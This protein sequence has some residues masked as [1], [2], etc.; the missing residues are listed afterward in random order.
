EV[1][2]E[3]RPVREGGV[4]GDPGLQRHRFVLRLAG[5]LAAGDVLTRLAVLDHLG[6]PLQGAHLGQPGDVLVV[7]LHLEAEVAVRIEAIGAGVHA[8]HRR[9]LS[10]ARFPYRPYAACWLTFCW[11]RRTTNSAGLSGANP[12]RMLTTPLS[13][14]V[15]VVVLLSHLT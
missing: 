6:R 9:G 2:D 8:G 4:V 11:S 5:Q 15:C 7:P 3:I 12:T 1:V 13:M 10:S 14:S